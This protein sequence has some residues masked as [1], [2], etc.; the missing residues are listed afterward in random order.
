[1]VVEISTPTTST[2][3]R[4]A[5]ARASVPGPVPT[6][7]YFRPGLGSSNSTARALYAANAGSL[8]T[9]SKT[10]IHAEGS[11][12]AS[13][14]VKACGGEFSAITDAIIT[15]RHRRTRFLFDR[16]SFHRSLSVDGD[17][18]CSFG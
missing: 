4:L 13:T 12:C 5:N 15:E 11:T 17:Q 9:S 18:G 7:R 1:M 2:P 10:R 8:R 14:F 16:P 3:N 6:S